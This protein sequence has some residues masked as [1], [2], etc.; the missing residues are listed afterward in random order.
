VV[1][2]GQR[3]ATRTPLRFRAIVVTLFLVLQFFLGMITN[4]YV[5]I[6]G[7]HPGANANNF[8]AGAARSVG[9]AI[10][11][12]PS[13]WLALHATLGLLLVL[14]ALEFIVA[15]VRRRNAVWAWSSIAGAAF[16]I[17]AAFNGASFLVF[18][19]DYSSL[20]MAGLFGL[21]LSSY[22]LG[23]YLDGRRT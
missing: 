8:F 2:V 18:D 20:I 19:K 12:S 6:P 14:G 22:A 16:I 4:L 3:A 21:S 13:V 9:W 17:G 15:A 10:S 1:T 5:T 11:A 23:M 7:S